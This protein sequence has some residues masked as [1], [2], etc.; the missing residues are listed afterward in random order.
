[1]KTKLTKDLVLKV[2]Q[3]H[4]GKGNGIGVKALAEQLDIDARSVRHWVTALRFDGIAVCGTPRDGYY[5]AQTEDELDET[6]AWIHSRSLH[7]L[8]MESQLRKIPF[9]DL[10]GQLHLPT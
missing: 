7:G 3:R 6:C 2:L 10:V 4:I 5:I 1:M 9:A 8:V